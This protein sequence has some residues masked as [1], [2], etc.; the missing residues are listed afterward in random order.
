MLGIINNCE[1]TMCMC[2]F[3]RSYIFLHISLTF[4]AVGCADYFNAFG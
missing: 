4:E 3:K 1:L 2:L